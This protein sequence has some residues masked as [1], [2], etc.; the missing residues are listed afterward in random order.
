MLFRCR[1]S[2]ADSSN[3]RPVS[4]SSKSRSDALI[5]CQ[6]STGVLTT[7][8]D[9]LTCKLNEGVY[10]FGCLHRLGTRKPVLSHSPTRV[11]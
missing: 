11:L 9:L 8:M 6:S 4:P 1:N 5:A 2:A 10:E 3:G 7:L